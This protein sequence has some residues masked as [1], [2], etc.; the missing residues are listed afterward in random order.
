[1]ESI[2]NYSK[3]QT[4]KEEIAKRISGKTN[5]LTKIAKKYIPKKQE[6]ECDLARDI[7]YECLGDYEKGEYSWKEFISELEKS[8][9][10]LKK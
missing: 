4:K 1:M 2:S 5:I 3:I 9:Q 8:L 7:F 6:A 10:A